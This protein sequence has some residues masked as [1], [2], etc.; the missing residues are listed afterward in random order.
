MIV[1]DLILPGHWL[2]KD[3]AWSHETAH[4]VYNVLIALRS[5]LDDCAA[6]LA[7]YDRSRAVGGLRPDWTARGEIERRRLHEEALRAL[8]LQLDRDEMRLRVIT[9]LRRADWKTG[10]A[11]Q[12][13]ERRFQFLHAESFV[14]HLDMFVKFL[15]KLRIVA[16]TH[17]RAIKSII[18]T[19][20]ASIG[21]DA[22]SVRDSIQHKDERVLGKGRHGALPLQPINSHGIQAAA[23]G[24]LVIGCLFGDRLA[25]TAEDGELKSAEVSAPTLL[26]L[27]EAAQAAHDAFT[28]TGGATYHPHH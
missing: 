2:T 17:D 20:E 25:Y 16:I 9:D 8:G 28:W 10:K 14:H 11:P 3:P 24:V 15:K 6:S 4:E 21:N 13:Y 7:L 26:A 12:I 18:D 19:L 22:K 23:G 27:Q 1:A 5:E